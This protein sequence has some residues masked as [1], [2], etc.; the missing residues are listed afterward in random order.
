MASGRL[1]TLAG[2]GLGDGPAGRSTGRPSSRSRRPGSGRRPGTTGAAGPRPAR[3]P[4]FARKRR[5]FPRPECGDDA[6][7]WKETVRRPDRRPDQGGHGRPR[8]WR[9][10]ASS[11]TRLIDFLRPAWSSCGATAIPAFGPARRDLNVFLRVVSVSIF[12][13]WSLGIASTSASGLTSEREEDT[14]ISLIAT[15]LT[16]R[17]ILRAKMIGPVWGLRPAGLPAVRAL[18][19]RPGL[20]SIHPFGVLA[21]LVELVVFTWFLDGARDG[22]LAPVARTARGR[23]PRRWPADLPQR[24]LPVLL[25]PDAARTPRRSSAGSTPVLFAVSL[26]QRGGPPRTSGRTTR[27]DHGRPASWASSSTGSPRRG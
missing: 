24:R 11:P 16:G 25:H 10:S 19:D 17:E 15:P 23:W 2:R 7:L 4:P 20:G 3:S 13:L 12:V 21:C 9:W 18:G 14:W 5:W 27:R 8:R 22:L 1:G 26:A 6:M